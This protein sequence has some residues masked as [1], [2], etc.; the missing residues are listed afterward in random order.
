MKKALLGVLAVLLAAVLAAAGYGVHL[1]G[2]LN[3][4]EFQKSLLDQ[5]KAAVGAEVRAKRMDI[6]LFSGVTLQGIAIANPAPFAGELLTA[7]A[8]VLRY[9]LRPLLAGRVEVE[10][11]ALE[12]PALSLA[13]DA[14]GA[15]NYEKLGGPAAKKPSA[16]APAGAA[17]V[18]LR[19]VLK[20]LAVENGSVTLADH[21][22]ARLLALEG[23]GFRSSFE[24]EGGTARGSG[25]A[26]IPKVGLGDR[27]FLRSVRAPLSLSK[28]AVALSPIRADVA[29]GRATGDVTVHLKGGFRYVVKLEVKGVDVSTLLAEAKSAGGV[30][31][32][33]AGQATFEG[34]GGLPTM[35]GRGQGTVS[36]CRVEQGRVLALLSAVLQ[37]PELANPD[38][39]ECRAEFTQSGTRL[40]TPVLL[41]TGEAVQL[42]GAGT[43]NLETTALDYQ[44]TLALA[45]RLFAKVT[46]P[47]LR[48][49]FKERADGYATVDFHL[50]GT[51]LEPKTDLLARVGTAA[52]TDAVKKGL[53]RLFGS[54][55]DSR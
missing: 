12:K 29:K 22:K 20:Q 49:A 40:A 38:F 55:N 3:T 4:P 32:T 33:L 39:D 48:P 34:S 17:A 8:F 26:T 9:R 52:A 46:R 45:P 19:I 10:R 35:K 14:R 54:K 23:A 50:Y 1:A 28:E 13:M 21:G 2:K 47:E 24:V 27:L 36:D 6:S 51:T 53:G 25:E 44:M 18:P 30:S 31:G 37:V 16:T 5:A 7:D 41:L 43:V 11:V 42:R 15:F